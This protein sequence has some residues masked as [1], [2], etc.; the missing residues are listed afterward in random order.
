MFP[1]KIRLQVDSIYGA[2]QLRLYREYKQKIG[3]L[4]KI[5]HLCWL[6][7]PP[8]TEDKPTFAKP[9]RPLRRNVT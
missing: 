4:V 9:F 2:K 6:S 5:D 1:S 7:R 3:V 8:K